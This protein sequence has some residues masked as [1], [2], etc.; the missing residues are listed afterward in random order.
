[1]TRLWVEQGTEMT[2]G[3][4]PDGQFSPSARPIAIELRDGSI[5]VSI[6]KF[7]PLTTAACGE[8]LGFRGAVRHFDVSAYH[9]D[10]DR[11]LL[12]VDTF[13]R[14]L[15]SV[16][17]APPLSAETDAS[18]AARRKF[19]FTR[20]GKPS[21]V[22]DDGVHFERVAYTAQIIV[23]AQGNTLADFAM[24]AVSAVPKG[25]ASI[26]LEL[27][28]NVE[29]AIGS[30]RERYFDP[31]EI[32][33]TKYASAI[34]AAVTKA[35]SQTCNSMAGKPSSDGSGVCILGADK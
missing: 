9:G 16:F 23:E 22:I 10:K 21:R 8:I 34:R 33:K 32:E 26:S 30:P 18:Q 2:P 35:V 4:I 17:E 11:V 20:D 31:S 27:A 15:R 7:D 24:D 13:I 1:M 19:W 5:F 12:A 29:L 25:A 14:H 28:P 3:L 6:E